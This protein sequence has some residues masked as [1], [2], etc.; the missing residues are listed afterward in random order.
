MQTGNRWCLVLLIAI[1]L[2]GCTETVTFEGKDRSLTYSCNGF[3][4]KVESDE[5]LEL[6]ALEMRKAANKMYNAGQTAR[7]ESLRTEIQTALRERDRSRFEELA[8]SAKC[9]VEHLSEEA[10]QPFWN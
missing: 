6:L 2:P 9:D 5:D 4:S 1:F 7:V 10:G 3:E 8:V